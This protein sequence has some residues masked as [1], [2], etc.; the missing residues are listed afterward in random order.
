[1]YIGW[2]LKYFASHAPI[3]RDGKRRLLK[4]ATASSSFKVKQAISPFS[5][6]RAIGRLI[7]MFLVFVDKDL[8]VGHVPLDDEISLMYTGSLRA[9]AE[10][11]FTMQSISHLSP[12]AVGYFCLI[13]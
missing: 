8:V 11:E 7:V 10:V 4:T 6:L 12:T 13:S 3:P 5:V 2:C 1:L 9:P